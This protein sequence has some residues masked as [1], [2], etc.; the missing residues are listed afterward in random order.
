MLPSLRQITEAVEGLFVLE[1]L[2]NFG[3]YYDST[4]MAWH[5]NFIRVWPNIKERY[6]D[7][8]FRK[9]TYYFLHLAGA[10]RARKNQL[11]QFVFSK[12]G[13]PGGY[14]PIR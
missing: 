10:F 2:H 12:N 13:I 3:E 7:R 4:L 8:C 14:S 9:W 11:W 6:D 1:D 5:E